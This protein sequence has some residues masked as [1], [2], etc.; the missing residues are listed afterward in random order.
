MS[1]GPWTAVDAGI[2][3]TGAAPKVGYPNGSDGAAP[4][5]LVGMFS[6][7]RSDCHL[8]LLNS[9]YNRRRTAYTGLHAVDEPTRTA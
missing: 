1:S 9:L 5:S 2:Y 4:P 3:G 6:R 7:A 8:S